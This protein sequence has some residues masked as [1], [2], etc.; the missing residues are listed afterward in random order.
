MSIPTVDQSAVRVAIA[1][2]DC[3]TGDVEAN[4]KLGLDLVDQAASQN[5]DLLV[6]PELSLTGYYVE[7][8]VPELA[9]TLNSSEIQKFVTATFDGPSIMLGFIEDGGDG[10][11]YNAA[12][13]LEQGEIVH[14][15]RKLYLP[16]YGLLSERRLFC[17]GENLSAFPTRF[18]KAAMLICEDAWHTSLPYLAV[19]G[20]ASLLL[21]MSASPTGGTSA[22]MTSEE[23]WTTVNRATAVTLKCF[24]VYANR[25]GAEGNIT[26]WGGSHLLSPSGKLV[27]KAPLNEETLLVADID[28]NSVARERYAYRYVADERLDI[29]LR[30]LQSLAQQRWRN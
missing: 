24:N 27:A 28:L 4:T 30:E 16:T 19:M 15:Q 6:F 3:V 25:V 21:T 9:R 13:Y 26:Y 23:L 22:D 18:G 5:V 12:A 7:G 10:Q 8:L 14:V 1:Q 29:T 11:Y 20:G 2:M 17:P